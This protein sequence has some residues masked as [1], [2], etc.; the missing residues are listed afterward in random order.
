[1]YMVVYLTFVFRINHPTYLQGDKSLDEIGRPKST[2][3]KVKVVSGNSLSQRRH[4]VDEKPSPTLGDTEERRDYA[5]YIIS[6]RLDK[7]TLHQRDHL[8]KIYLP[9]VQ[10]V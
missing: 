5:H 3:K 10:N 2:P 6:Q 8:H 1:M 7:I 9:F 4:L